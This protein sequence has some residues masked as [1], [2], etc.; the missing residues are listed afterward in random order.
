MKLKSLLSFFLFI[1]SAIMGDEI[2]SEEGKSTAELIA[3]ADEVLADAKQDNVSAAKEVG[4]VFAAADRLLHE[5]KHEAAKAYF[6]KGLQMSPWDMDAQL[7]Y[8]T[9]LDKLGDRERAQRAAQIVLQASE[10]QAL[11]EEAA[12]IAKTKLPK[13][14]TTLPDKQFADKVFCFVPIGPVQEWV[15]SRSGERLSATLGVKIYVYSETLLLPAPHR[16]YFEH[17]T[18]KLKEGIIWDHP[19]V[20]EQMDEIGIVNVA[21]ADIDQVLELLARIEV[22]QGKE[23]PRPKFARMIKDA[24]SRDKQWDAS[25]LLAKLIEKV[26]AKQNVVYIGISEGDL[27]K[28]DNN[29]LFGIARTGG[30]FALISYCRYQSRFNGERESQ[31]R[32]LDRIHKQLL[33]SSGFALG[34]PRPTDPRSARSYPNGLDDHDLKGTWLAPECIR[35]FE[36]AL[37]HS[38]PLKTKEE[39]KQAMSTINR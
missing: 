4:Q 14:L 6:E 30:D 13:S 25:I 36:D 22:A 11:L 31:T 3:L 9:V 32:L 16:S 37:G 29:Y 39:S 19:W 2:Q 28:N 26:E 5:D 33:S 35:G 38:L 27:Y 18:K 17:W 10:R 15:L 34:I 7:A 12:I 21:R 24:K 1:T 20:I 8:A 23:D